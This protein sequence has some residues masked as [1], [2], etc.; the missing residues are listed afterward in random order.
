MRL[1]VRREQ[2][3]VMETVA[4]AAFERRI[5]DHL[6]AEYPASVVKL[7][8]GG[9]FAVAELEDETLLKLVAAGVARA[10]SHLMKKESSIAP[11][12]ALMFDVSPN[13]DKHRLCQV[14]LTDVEHEPDERVGPMLD[15]LTDEN[16]DSIRKDYDPQA[17]DEKPEEPAESE[18][19]PAAEAAKP[20][21]PAV[22]D[23]DPGEKTVMVSSTGSPTKDPTAD[24]KLEKTHSE[25]KVGIETV[26]DKPKPAADKM[27]KTMRGGTK[28][29]VPSAP[30][31]GLETMIIKRKD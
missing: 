22:R 7:P 26:V 31:F 9:E 13:F 23:E 27:Q 10:R 2:M 3:E 18:T 4:Q 24:K 14:L 20:E 15:V 8:E 28:K 12:V 19:E 25:S 30:D 17:W 21:T 6:I 16:W 1:T 29:D 11:F 5:A